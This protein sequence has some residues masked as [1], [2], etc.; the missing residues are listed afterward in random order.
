M[1][2][3]RKDRICLLIAA[4]I[5][6]FVIVGVSMLCVRAVSGTGSRETDFVFGGK[7][8]LKNTIEIPL[9]EAECLSVQYKSK[10][11]RVYPVQGEK[12]I[13]KEY[14]H[15]KAPEALAAVIYEDEKKVTVKGG[16]RNS[17][18]VFGFWGSVERIEVYVPEKSLKEF[19]VETKS[20]NIK[21]ETDCIREDGILRVATKSGNINWEGADGREL[22]F[23]S[24]SGN[25]TGALLDGEVDVQTGSGNIRLSSL[26]GNGRA[27]AGSGNITAD[28]DEVTGDIQIQTGSGNV[29]LEVP[30]KLEFQ[31]RADTGSGNIWTDFEEVLSYNKRENNAEGDVGENA[32]C[33]I[34][35]ETGSGN[36]H[37]DRK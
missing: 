6:L 2:G 19:S 17:F 23:E 13:I 11:I 29:K 25:I 21:S 18:I 36:I 24:G 9:S 33:R 10:N 22:S 31:F 30:E 34:E 37:V 8:E 3:M 27:K 35:A 7:A 15:S 26:S 12:I 20:G 16:E 14:L 4:C 28:F 1:T 32:S 5:M